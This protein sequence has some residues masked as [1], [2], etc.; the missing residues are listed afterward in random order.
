M[1]LIEREMNDVGILFMMLLIMNEMSNEEKIFGLEGILIVELILFDF[2]EEFF[3][4]RSNVMIGVVIV[5]IFSYLIYINESGINDV[6]N[7]V[8]KLYFVKN[9]NYV[10]N[11]RW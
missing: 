11:V 10:E 3:W 1:G 2:V 5:V 8:E 9:K 6:G 4:E 7:E